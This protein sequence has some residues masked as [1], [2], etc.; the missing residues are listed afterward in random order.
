MIWHGI[1][2]QHPSQLPQSQ[3]IHGLEGPLTPFLM[4]EVEEVEGGMVL[5]VCVV[6]L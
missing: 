1:T 2:Q 6:C 5:L 4:L 3:G